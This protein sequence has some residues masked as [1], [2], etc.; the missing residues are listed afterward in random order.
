[1]QLRASWGADDQL[2]PRSF[3]FNHFFFLS[4]AQF[5]IIY[6]IFMSL[7][8]SKLYLFILFIQEEIKGKSVGLKC[9]ANQILGFCSRFGFRA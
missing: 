8:S 4:F 9:Q 6:L 5:I 7:R 3:S 1:M 2:D